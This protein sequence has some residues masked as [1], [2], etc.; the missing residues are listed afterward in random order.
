VKAMKKE[1][2]TPAL[3]VLEV[4]STMQGKGV[5]LVDIVSVDDHDLYS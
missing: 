4:S 2:Q 1:W 3:E 5:T